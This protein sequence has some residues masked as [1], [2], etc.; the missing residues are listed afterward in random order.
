M[1]TPRRL[2]CAA[3][4]SCATCALAEQAVSAEGP[5]TPPT[6]DVAA[7]GQVAFTLQRLGMLADLKLRA[8]KQLYLSDSEFFQDN[9]MSAGLSAQLSPVFAHAGAQLDLQPASFFKLSGGY[10]F[11]GY[12]GSLGSLRSPTDCTGL[13]RV[14]ATDPRCD[15]HPIGFEDNPEGVAATGHRLWLE[16]QLMGRIGP[17]IAVGAARVERWMMNSPGQYWVNELYGVAQ[18]RNDTVI[19]GGGALLYAVLDP[20]GR[21]P[22]L[23]VGAADDLAWSLGTDSF[24]NRVGPVAMLRAPKWGPWRDVSAQL[25]VLFYTHERYLA[26]SPYLAFA[27]SAATPNFFSR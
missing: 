9:F 13:S 18:S 4:I 11:V 17:V 22:E 23:L 6:W 3:L 25:A 10:H 7:E 26:G 21:R 20:V 12:F 15:F 27:V 2:L 24:Y 16:A 8:K 19:T 5:T 1:P 14:A